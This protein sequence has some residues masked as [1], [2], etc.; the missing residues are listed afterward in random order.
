VRCAEGLVQVEVHH[1]DAQIAGAGDAHDGIEI[2]AI[3]INQ[4]ANLVYHV[5]DL[6]DVLLE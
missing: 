3:T 5:A 4:S 6:D 1:I 2:G